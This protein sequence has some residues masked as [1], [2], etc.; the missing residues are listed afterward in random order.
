MRAQLYFQ[1][2][3]N[4]LSAQ[5]WRV[6]YVNCDTPGSYVNDIVEEWLVTWEKAPDIFIDL[7]PIYKLLK[8]NH[9]YNSAEK[10]ERNDL[11][12]CTR[13]K[14]KCSYPDICKLTQ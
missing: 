5:E 2:D 4:N 8:V 14:Y 3:R 1:E 6:S 10:R 11:S 12:N 9:K 7:L 13:I